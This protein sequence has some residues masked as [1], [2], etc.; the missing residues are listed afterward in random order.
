MDCGRGRRVLQEKSYRI[1]AIISLS[2]IEASRHIKMGVGAL[3]EEPRPMS[4]DLQKAENKGFPMR[5]IT[6]L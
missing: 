6:F 5:Y 2:W 3:I 1:L 4:L